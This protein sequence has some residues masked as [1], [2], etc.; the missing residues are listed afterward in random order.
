M[1]QARGEI[2]RLNLLSSLDLKI[3]FGVPMERTKSTFRIKK[4]KKVPEESGDKLI[5]VKK[6]RGSFYMFLYRTI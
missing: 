1:P 6:G 2:I 3:D 4:R 5:N